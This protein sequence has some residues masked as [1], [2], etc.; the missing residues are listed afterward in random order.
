MATKKP[1]MKAKARPAAN[2]TAKGKTTK[3]AIRKPATA[4]AKRTPA[5][6]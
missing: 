2:A 1:P 6:T 3:T 4:G 5:S